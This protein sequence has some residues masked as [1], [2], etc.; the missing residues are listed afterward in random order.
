MTTLAGEGSISEQGP[1]TRC[2]AGNRGTLAIPTCLSPTTSIMFL[3]QGGWTWEMQ[4]LVPVPSFTATRFHSKVSIQGLPPLETWLLNQARFKRTLVVF[5]DGQVQQTLRRHWI[6]L[7]P[8]TP[9]ALWRS[10]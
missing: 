5:G 4:G 9:L 2:V 7:L 3:G 10:T 8:A 6:P 1:L